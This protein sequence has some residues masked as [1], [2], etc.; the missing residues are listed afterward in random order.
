MMKNIGPTTSD[1]L[2]A[3]E[4]KFSEEDFRRLAI[5]NSRWQKKEIEYLRKILELEKKVSHL[6]SL[7]IGNEFE[8]PLKV[9]SAG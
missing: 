5:E 7:L 8:S 6:N 9:T 1:Q 2:S 3:V 4:L